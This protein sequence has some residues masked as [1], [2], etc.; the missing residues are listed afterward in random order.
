M[1]S[2]RS[3]S[4]NMKPGLLRSS[5]LSIW[6]EW[7]RMAMRSNRV[8]A[9]VPALRTSPPA[10]TLNQELPVDRLHQRDR[11]EAR[12]RARAPVDGVIR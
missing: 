4:A 9:A 5:G 3:A 11:R 10:T 1:A 6:Q 2:R 8:G 12:L 7:V